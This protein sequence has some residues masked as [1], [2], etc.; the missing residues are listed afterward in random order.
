MMVVEQPNAVA[1]DR[2][3]VVYWV[4]DIT[5]GKLIYKTLDVF[6]ER[7]NPIMSYAFSLG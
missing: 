3:S 1:P 2:Q 4:A 5:V 6:L 7:I